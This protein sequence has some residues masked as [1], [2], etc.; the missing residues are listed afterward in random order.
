M[1]LAKARGMSERL[2]RTIDL[3]SPLCQEDAPTNREEMR[4]AEAGIGNLSHTNRKQDT[5]TFT[6]SDV[7]PMKST[8]DSAG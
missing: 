5:A 4:Q 7:S 6:C 2:V 8:D 3:E 1:D